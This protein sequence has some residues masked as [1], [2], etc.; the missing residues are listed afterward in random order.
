M[1]K[2]RA[3]EF[4]D[5]DPTECDCG[6]NCPE[7]EQKYRALHDCQT[8]EKLLSEIP[9]DIC[10]RLFNAIQFSVTIKWSEDT[11]GAQI[12]LNITRKTILN[13]TGFAENSTELPTNE[14]ID[15]LNEELLYGNFQVQKYIDKETFAG[16][17]HQRE[18]YSYKG[19]NSARNSAKKPVQEDE[20]PAQECDYVDADT[21]D[22]IPFP[23]VLDPYN[24]SDGENIE[25]LINETKNMPAAAKTCNFSKKKAGD[26]KEFNEK[27]QPRKFDTGIEKTTNNNFIQN[28]TEDQF[29]NPG[30]TDPEKLAIFKQNMKRLYTN[31]NMG[32]LKI[33]GYR[34]GITARYKN[35]I[36]NSDGKFGVLGEDEGDNNTKCFY[37]NCDWV[38]GSSVNRRNGMKRHVEIVHMN[39]RYKCP[40]PDCDKT[41]G[42]K[43]RAKNHVLQ[44]HNDLR[45][46]ACKYCEKKF[47]DSGTMREHEMI[48]T[49]E[50]PWKCEKCGKGFIQ[51]N[52]WKVHCKKVC[53]IEPVRN[54]RHYQ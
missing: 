21:G 26:L 34:N 33:N 3:P 50:R 44:I 54:G 28:P 29:E 15:D 2:R 43:T 37:P 32:K 7:T 10:Q 51:R 24:G 53:G 48:H 20:V 19:Q 38:N 17:Y 23:E 31:A 1:P 14:R 45:R 46:Y 5:D 18:H 42:T 35:K 49:G 11:S 40:Y 30:I 41:F 8:I 36:D 12:T 52:P 13:K 22:I 25:E 9:I 39:I 47:R 4:Y 27:R 6:I 16:K